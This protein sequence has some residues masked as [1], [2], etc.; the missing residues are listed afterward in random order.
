M[1]IFVYGT[2]KR[3]NLLSCYLQRAEFIGEARTVR[4]E[5]RMFCN[6]YYPLVTHCDHGYPILGELFRV[7]SETLEEL[8]RVENGYTR[9]VSLFL[10]A[11]REVEGELYIGPYGDDLL[12]IQEVTGGNW[13]P[14][15]SIIGREKYFSE[16]SE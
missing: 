5:F 11:G 3:E 1:I 14:S 12:S 9:M 2:L 8:D 16:L 4:A 10:C 7:D 15:T 13:N 6:G